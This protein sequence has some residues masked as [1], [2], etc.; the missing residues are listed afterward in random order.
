MDRHNLDAL[1]ATTPENVAYLTGFWILTSLRHRNRQVYAIV[2]RDDFVPAMVISK[3]LMDSPLTGETWVGQYYLYGQF[4]FAST[5]LEDTDKE[6]QKLSDAVSSLSSHDSA[7]SALVKCLED[8][9]LSKSN[10]GFDQGGDLTFAR[11][12]LK[13]R[14]PEIEITPSYELFRE[15]RAV[16]T[17]AEIT[18]IKRA[19]KV[20]ETALYVSIKALRSGVTEEQIERVFHQSI[21]RQGGLPTLSCIGFGPRGAFPNVKPSLRTLAIGDAVR[22]DVGCIVDSYHS[23]IARTAVLG[24]PSEKIKKYFDALLAGQQKIMDAVKPGVTGNYLFEIGMKEVQ[25]Q[26]IPHYERQHCGHGN[27]IEGYD[28]PLVAP[29]NEMV[30]E[31]GMVICVETP[32]YELGLAGLQIEDIIVVTENGFECLTSL[33]RKLFVV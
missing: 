22:Y 5:D 1:V 12:G 9:G 4:Y 29:G 15:I 27:G 21:A 23:D 30:F 17:D 8:K 13:Q 10:I 18:R 3:G 20:D 33:E 31:P 7:L 24:S 28:Y 2:T 32:Y 25:K 14:L 16:K 19:V 6:S 26:G 11:D